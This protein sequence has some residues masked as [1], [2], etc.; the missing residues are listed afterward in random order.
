MR[1][2]VTGGSGFLGSVLTKYLAGRGHEVRALARTLPPSDSPGGR[3]VTWLQGDLSSPRDAAAL[4]ADADAILHLAWTNT[5]LTSNAHLPSDATA[6]LVP[7]LTLLEAVR[8]RSAPPHVVFASSGGAVYGVAR[9]RRPLREDDPCRPESSYGIQKLM[10]EHY[11]RMA[12]EHRWLTAIALRM[13]NPYGV[14]LPPE[15]LQGFIGTAVVQLL[16]GDPI[17]I[18]GNR[19]NVRDYVH[20]ADVCRAVELSLP[21]RE[22]F[23]VFNIGS[24]TAH[25]VDEVLQLVEA[26]VGRPLYVRT[27]SS[28]AADALPSWV[29]LDVAKAR[30]QLD[31]VPE[32]GL[33]EGLARL[34]SAA[35]RT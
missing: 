24:G 4:V 25:S 17:R 16:A 31:W 34:I 23:D 21:A 26:V 20:I 33:E 18:F 30:H 29:V 10:V 28:A 9:D 2:A 3:A 15:R 19:A 27:E 6:N 22:P 8:V 5:P 35:E 13:G 32:I 12:A 7:T 1:V 14:R 11:L